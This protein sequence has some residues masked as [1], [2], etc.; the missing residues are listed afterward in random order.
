[1]YRLEALT[2]S[3]YTF[4]CFNLL[5]PF[6]VRFR[7]FP[8]PFIIMLSICISKL[9]TDSH[10]N[11]QP[12][13]S[14]FFLNILKGI[15]QSHIYNETQ[16]TLQN[17][18]FSFTVFDCRCLHLYALMSKPSAP[19]ITLSAGNRRSPPMAYWFSSVVLSVFLKSE[20]SAHLALF[21][22]ITLRINRFQQFLINLF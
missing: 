18:Y 7:T 13:H 10:A 4:M 8:C 16:Y 2:S 22:A 3:R 12:L 19:P 21:S 1:M 14:Y 5:I 20:K 15:L 9:L 6:C 17:I 11:Q